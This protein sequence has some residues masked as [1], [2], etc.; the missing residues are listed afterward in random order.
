MRSLLRST[1]ANP[2]FYYFENQCLSDNSKDFYP[3]IYRNYVDDIF[4][5][6]DSHKQLKKLVEYM[7][8]K[9]LDI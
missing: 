3:N 1:L 7:N 6:F 4:V 9:D 2:F 8:K 5:F